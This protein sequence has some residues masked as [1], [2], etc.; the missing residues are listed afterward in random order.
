LKTRHLKF[1]CFFIA[2]LLFCQYIQAQVNW[3]QNNIFEPKVFVENK[4]QNEFDPLPNHD[5]IIYTANI[6]G[7]TYFFTKC[8][9]TVSHLKKKELSEDNLYK[10]KKD[11]NKEQEEENEEEVQKYKI[12]KEYHELK[13]INTNSETEI[14]SDSLMDNYYAYPDF[15][16][17]KKTI[18]AHTC[19]KIIYKNIYPDID[20]FFEFPKDSRGIKCSV[21]LHPGAN[22]EEI[23]I[24]F[25]NEKFSLSNNGNLEIVSGFGNIMQPLSTS[26]IASTKKEI[27]SNYKLRE[28]YVGFEA[29]NNR[30]NEIIIESWIVTPVF[31]FS[32]SAFDVDYDN[33]GN[34]YVYGGS[35]WSPYQLLK[36]NSS[37]SLIWTYIS[38]FSDG[39]YGDFAVDRNSKN[40]YLVEG[41]N[42]TGAHV[43]KINSNAMQLATFEGNPNLEEMWRIAFS[44]CN[45][46]VVIAGGGPTSVNQTCTLDTNLLN[47]NPV[48]FVP[49]AIGR[50]DVALLALD[51][52][53]NCYE[54]TIFHPDGMFS[55]QLVRLPLPKLLPVIF[56]INAG[57]EF[58]EN[59]TI[60]YFTRQASIGYNGIASYKKMVYT[61]DS[62][63]LRKWNGLNGALLT[64][65]QIHYPLPIGPSKI[66][67]GGISSD[68]C[69]N[70]FLADSNIVKQ[71]DSTLNLVNTYIMPGVITDISISNKGVLYTCGLGFVA[72]LEPSKISACEDFKI[73]IK[74]VNATCNTNGSASV[75]VKGGEKPYS[76]VWNTNPVQYGPTIS[77]LQPGNYSVSVTEGS[78]K[79]LTIGNAF[80]ILSDNHMETATV[81]VRCG[82][83]YRL[84]WGTIVNQA[85]TYSDTV[86]TVGGCDSIVSRILT[87]DIS[88]LDLKTVIPNAFS[89]NDDGINDQLCFP[90]NHCVEKINM[91]I[92]DRWGEKVYE[93]NSL[94]NCWDGTY[95]GKKLE[96][97]V[98]VYYL[99]VE[100]TG[101][102][103]ETLKGNISLIK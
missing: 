3:K 78:C 82:Q 57:Y 30:N 90:N 44:E 60:Q 76:I 19:K 66:Y 71:Y 87:Y 29:E 65:K 101:G 58:N 33:Q 49:N 10:K 79:S 23:K 96:S 1:F 54:G 11:S 9:F 85:G 92:Y 94:K 52:F 15:K 26:Y 64:T 7:L 17:S 28:K 55:N 43:V 16:N 59:T 99:T 4:G 75:F 84:P 35:G 73:S 50:H 36:Y 46:Q 93:T 77:N 37:G 27:E 13:F 32:N 51:K 62:Y 67:W 61:Y 47:Y 25:P 2:S 74:T 18:I 45:N 6:D 41:I 63:Q 88:S 38:P 24:D 22:V 81:S 20:I 5:P 56:N 21:Y 40:I 12:V 91:A 102:G 68:E 95:K 103:R 80:T 39:L 70:L 86:K 100:F 98:F 31:E 14:V 72:S 8:G 42:G 48:Q 83:D 69:G 89:P 97:A 53:G 34:V